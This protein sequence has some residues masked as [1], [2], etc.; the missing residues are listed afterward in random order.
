MAAQYSI[1]EL[2][3]FI[4]QDIT[5]YGALPKSL[6]DQSIRQFVETRALPWFQINYLYAV[7]LM[8]YYIDQAAFQT[9]EFTRFS[10]IT[11]PCEIQSISWIHQ[12]RGINMLQLGLNS[13]NLSVN[14]GV[15]NQPY[16][17]SYVTTIGELGTYKAII[18][19]MSDMLDQMTLFT[20]KYNFN[21]QSSRLN[22]LTKINTS[23]ILECY[24]NIPQ[25]NLFADPYF[26]KYVTGWAKQQ[27][28]NLLGR[29]DFNLPG[30]VKINTADM[31]AQGKEE[32]KEVEEEIKNSNGNSSFFIMV[33]K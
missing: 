29:Y 9:E 33:K 22:I 4:Q 7:S 18:D 1:E 20:T 16:L 28:G 3:D 27:Q 8:Y 13:P 24:V 15:T 11:L 26:I 5:V 25:E 14:L 2:I 6:P 10:Y 17:S 21:V 30:S 19:S 31:I 32:M 23:L 12:V